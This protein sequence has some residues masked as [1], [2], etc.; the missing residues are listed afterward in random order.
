MTAAVT[1]N[2]NS[3][4]GA[5]QI[6]IP[7]KEVKIPVPWGNIVA[8]LWGNENKRPLLAIHGW[9]DNCGVWDP[10][11]SLISDKV[12]I[13]AIDMPGHGFS[14]WLPPGIVYDTWEIVR[15]IQA[16]KEYLK[17]DKVSILGHSMGSIGGARYCGL[18]PEDVD[19]V[20]SVEN[21]VYEDM[22][23]NI[24]LQMHIFGLKKV[25]LS[26]SFEPTSEPPAYTMEEIIEKWYL[27]ADK[28]ILKENIPYLVKQGVKPST[29]HPGKFFFSRD[30]RVKYGS[31]TPENNDYLE[32]LMRRVKCP[33]LYFRAKDS[34]Y[35]S[36]SKGFPLKVQK[37]L[38][39]NN[40]HY[41][42]HLVE[43]T[44]HIHINNADKLA[45]V[46]LEFLAKHNRFT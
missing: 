20:M 5:E 7:V 15:C 40:P 29:K 17:W 2:S 31:F 33:V 37:L 8:K 6:Q 41:E 4:T 27:G 30:I 24:R 11:A 19:M 45:P 39:E 26:K 42:S 9:Q 32:L 21:F 12:P 10:L 34:H 22:D 28:S 14:S 25:Q 18:F 13:L 1:W 44:H 23:I 38:Q 16:I 35:K 3:S 36:L 43:G 46:I